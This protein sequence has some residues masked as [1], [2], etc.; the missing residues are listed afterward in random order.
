[1]IGD[2][3][4]ILSVVGSISKKLGFIDVV[5]SDYVCKFTR[6]D[7]WEISLLGERYYK[8]G[9]SIFISNR[10]SD[11]RFAVWILMKVFQDSNRPTA[12]NQMKFIEKK[13]NILF[14]KELSYKEMHDSIKL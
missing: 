2:Y 7:G 6:N 8:P 4:D 11:D 5:D 14:S 1:M 12:Y 10:N 3:K 9:F 13:Q